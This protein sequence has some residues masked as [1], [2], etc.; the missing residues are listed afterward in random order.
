MRIQQSHGS[1]FFFF[2]ACICKKRPAHNYATM[3]IVRAQ[4][5]CMHLT[6]A[7]FHRPGYEK[8]LS[9]SVCSLLLV[10][11]EGC[12]SV[13]PRLFVYWFNFIYR[14]AQI[15]LSVDGLCQRHLSNDRVEALNAEVIGGGSSLSLQCCPLVATYSYNRFPR[16]LYCNHFWSLDLKSNTNRLLNST[17]RYILMESTSWARVIFT[18]RHCCYFC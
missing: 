14:S 1:F 5:I 18:F 6:D 13:P 4:L 9:L 10:P 8:W 17:L 11:L 15:S 12:S 2:L 16:W 7:T 3:W